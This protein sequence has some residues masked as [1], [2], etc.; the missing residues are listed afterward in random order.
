VSKNKEEIKM[1]SNDRPATK[2]FKDRWNHLQAFWKH[3]Q[4]GFYDRDFT[5]WRIG[6]GLTPRTARESYWDAGETLG[7]IRLFYEKGQKFWEYCSVDAHT[8]SVRPKIEDT[9]SKLGDTINAR[10]IKEKM[11]TGPCA[12]ECPHPENTDCRKCSTFWN[13]KNKDFLADQEVK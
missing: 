2:A 10:I 3:R 1:S 4:R 5:E 12:H 13:L 8:E 11:L 9:K 6:H 7:I